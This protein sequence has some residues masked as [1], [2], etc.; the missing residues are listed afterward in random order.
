MRKERAYMLLEK[1]TSREATKEGFDSSKR[2]DLQASQ[3]SQPS[4]LGR[5]SAFGK[6]R[7]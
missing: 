2:I 4:M 5:P 7:F 1:L 3:P 6:K